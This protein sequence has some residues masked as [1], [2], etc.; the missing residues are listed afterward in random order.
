MRCRN[1]LLFSATLLLAAG[2]ATPVFAL[3][4]EMDHH[5]MQS[6]GMGG[7]PAAGELSP[8]LQAKLEADKR[9]SEFNHRFA[10]VFVILA[11]LLALSEPLIAKRFQS[12]GYLWAAFFF[13]PGVYLFF[14][15]D[16]ESWPVGNQTLWHVITVNHQVLQH[17][18]FSIILLV[19]GVVE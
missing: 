4:S 2:L 18:I 9:F 10:G 17:K 16:P 1:C 15:S 8:A 7:M 6:M 11:G 12:F 19:L 5:H 13:M 3:Q 14:W